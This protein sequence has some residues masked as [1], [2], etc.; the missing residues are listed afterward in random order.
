MRRRFQRQAGSILANPS[1]APTLALELG[2]RRVARAGGGR[3]LGPLT[4]ALPRSIRA[5]QS[6]MALGAGPYK[7]EAP[8]QAR[9]PRP[10]SD[11]TAGPPRVRSRDSRRHARGRLPSLQLVRVP[12][13]AP[14]KAA[15]LRRQNLF[16]AQVAKDL[17]D[18]MLCSLTH[19]T[20]KRLKSPQAAQGQLLRGLASWA[21]HLVLQL[22]SARTGRRIDQRSCRLKSKELVFSDT[23]DRSS[24]PKTDIV[25]ARLC[26]AISLSN[27]AGTHQQPQAPGG[28]RGQFESQPKRLSCRHGAATTT[29]LCFCVETG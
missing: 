15:H 7:D 11:S 3:Q 28:L 6:E 26:G 20:D 21:A 10:H 8:A 25:S 12:A 1:R 5:G 19:C 13:G 17:R 4:L 22:G 27:L 2:G 9:K 16:A 29:A 14:G 18:P 23:N 24:R